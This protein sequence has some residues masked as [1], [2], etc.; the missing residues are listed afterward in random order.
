M[1][2]WDYIITNGKELRKAI[3]NGYARPTLKALLLCYEELYNKL[4]DEDKDW[5]GMEIEDAIETLALTDTNDIEEIDEYLEEFYD[6]CD[7]LRAWIEI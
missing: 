7:S 6:L 1:S 5:K 4:N 2:K 3:D